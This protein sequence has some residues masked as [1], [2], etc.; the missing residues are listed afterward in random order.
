MLLPRE[1]PLLGPRG[2]DS[3]S[4]ENFDV[5]NANWKM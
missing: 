2:D 4:S 3:T 5:L 1:S